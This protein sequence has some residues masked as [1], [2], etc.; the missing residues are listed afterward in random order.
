MRAGARR[1]A[2]R[3]QKATE[4]ETCISAP[5]GHLWSIMRYDYVRK[6]KHEKSAMARKYDA[7]KHLRESGVSGA[8]PDSLEVMTP[9]GTKTVGSLEVGD[10]LFSADGTPTKVTSVERMPETSD[11]LILCLKDGRCFPCT[12]QT[13]YVVYRWTHRGPD[14]ILAPVMKTINE[15]AEHGTC[16]TWVKKTLNH[17]YFY[18]SPVCQPVQYEPADLPVDPYVVG[19]FLGD[20]NTGEYATQLSLSCDPNDI[21]TVERGA[22]LIGAVGYA[23]SSDDN[24]SWSFIMP[25]EDRPNNRRKYFHVTDI[26]GDLPELIHN[27]GEKRIPE[28]YKRGSVEQR[29]ALVQGLMDTDGSINKQVSDASNKAKAAVS[30][31]ST[32]KRL[33]FDMLGM[34][35]GLGLE[36]TVSLGD[37]RGEEREHANGKTYTRKS[38][39][40]CIEIVCPNDMK[41]QLFRLSRKVE[42]A[43]R[44]EKVVARRDYR[45]QAITEILKT[46]MTVGT[47][48]IVVDNESHLILSKD[49]VVIHDSEI[50][51]LV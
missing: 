16:K 13:L 7:S 33:I 47:S 27:A 10:T 19:V 48:R 38:V 51:S 20:G 30:F 14:R 1:G 29:L 36:A 28:P 11:L 49:Y 25:E 44:V 23:R 15:I 46:G 34:L 9:D 12:S 3:G 32:S 43:N 22:Q 42:R 31:A 45:Y 5:Q 35:W 17:L 50:H 41:S 24:Y 6:P 21:E 26:F 37:R 18:R 2:G 8:L 39:E 4:E 40:Y